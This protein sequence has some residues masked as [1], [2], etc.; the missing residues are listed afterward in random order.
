MPK[1]PYRR[2]QTPADAQVLYLSDTEDD[3][4]SQSSFGIQPLRYDEVEETP[5]NEWEQA[6]DKEPSSCDASDGYCTPAQRPSPGAYLTESYVDNLATTAI[7]AARDLLRGHVAEVQPPVRCEVQAL[8][9]PSQY[10]NQGVQT[11]ATTHVVDCGVQTMATTHVDC[12][13][14]ASA[15][16][17]LPIRSDQAGHTSAHCV[18]HKPLSP[19]PSTVNIA[20][21]S[22]VQVSKGCSRAEKENCDVHV[23]VSSKLLDSVETNTGSLKVSIR[24]EGNRRNRKTE[25]FVQHKR[26]KLEQNYFIDISH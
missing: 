19:H 8:V 1:T 23:C 20:E 6:E 3:L 9:N 14:Q 16:G 17:E 12:G 15:M 26:R 25:V 11:M 24:E 13:V 5:P 4:S 2:Q 21:Q 7:A 10:S 22:E 18:H